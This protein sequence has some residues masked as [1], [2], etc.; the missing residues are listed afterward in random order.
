MDRLQK[1]FME[2]Q[3]GM[4]GT[5]RTAVK[6]AI[7]NVAQRNPLGRL[8]QLFDPTSIFVPLRQQ[9]SR[10]LTIEIFPE[11]TLVR[12]AI[13]S[14]DKKSRIVTERHS[15]LGFATFGSLHDYYS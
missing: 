2:P 6:R 3:R 13:C 12:S 4:R 8:F 11:A 5:Y 15:V 9:Q 1:S 14:C 10:S 7:S